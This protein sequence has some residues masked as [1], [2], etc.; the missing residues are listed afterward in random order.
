MEKRVTLRI[1]E[2]K[3]HGK[4]FLGK[5]DIW[6]HICNVVT[7]SS[8]QD[9]NR[10]LKLGESFVILHLFL[11]SLTVGWGRRDNCPHLHYCGTE[12]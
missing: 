4:K 3:T 2:P 1:Q 11:P 5:E 6:S 12:K 7:E 8:G 9:K 10:C